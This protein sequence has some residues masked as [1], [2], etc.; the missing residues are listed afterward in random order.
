MPLEHSFATFGKSLLLVTHSNGN[1]SA[2][3]F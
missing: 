3:T 2:A 1:R